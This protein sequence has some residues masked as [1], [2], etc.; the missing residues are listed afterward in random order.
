MD[1]LKAITNVHTRA[2]GGLFSN[3]NFVLL[4]GGRIVSQLGDQVYAFALSWY[5][6]DLTRSSTQMAI[7]L[8]IDT[9]VVA[10]TSP[11]GGI[12]ADQHD[13]K[14]IL[15][16]MDG[17]RGMTVLA[18]AVLLHQ[19]WL[20]IWMLY[21]SA[22][23]LGVCGA[24]FA[25]AAG[26]IVPNIVGERQLGEATSANQFTSSLCAMLGMLVSGLLYSWIGLFAIFLLNAGS[27]FISGVMEAALQVPPR[28]PSAKPALPAR[29][30]AFRPR[31]GETAA[32][33]ADGYQTVK[34]N[35]LVYDLLV[36][37]AIFN[38]V[39]LP[40]P[41]VYLPYFF[42]V[43]LRAAPVELALPQA[44][45]WLGMIAASFGVSRA[46]R[47]CRLKTL[48]LRGLLLLGLCTLAGVPWFVPQIAQRFTIQQVSLA[49]TVTSFICGLAVNLFTIPMY[50]IY[51][52]HTAD[53]FRGRFWGIENAVRTAALAG[54][55]LVSGF[56]AQ[57]VW[58]GALF[59]GTAAAL[60][61]LALWTTERLAVKACDD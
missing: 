50:V 32:Q 59:L 40:V 10:I 22:I 36:M 19:H 60:A 61:G 33:L 25:P 38:F 42:N 28:T 44:A 34:A 41:L 48:I 37:N 24:L 30:V 35:R 27:F 2:D 15:V 12:L 17:L 3:R 47:R 1:M 53:A 11:L 18:A 52:R 51:Q 45:I 56:L 54:S 55:V 21:L 31:L 39:A 7:F 20:S 43:V 8:V 6:L 5:I 46:L 16:W 58:L 57:R 29:P 26:A 9:L 4:F 23:V 13:R 49:W 14:G